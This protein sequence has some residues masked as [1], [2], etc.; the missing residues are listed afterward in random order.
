[1]LLVQRLS[2]LQGLECQWES[3]LLCIENLE[4]SL[5]GGYIFYSE[6]SLLYRE[7]RRLSSP[8]GALSQFHAWWHVF[9][10]MGT[11][12]HIVIRYNYYRGIF[13]S[14]DIII[15]DFHT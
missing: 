11:Y 13:I 2:F 10:G 1:M 6:C 12:L 3:S 4:S 8:L 7:F 9:A 5:Y 15:M 14:C